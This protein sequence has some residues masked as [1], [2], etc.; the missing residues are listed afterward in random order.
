MAARPSPQEM[1]PA[2]FGKQPTQAAPQEL[3]PKDLRLL[4]WSM[5]RANLRAAGTRNGQ[6]Q[7]RLA[8]RPIR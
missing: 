4:Q 2:L 5:Q 8:T 3:G 7:P 6:A 1:F